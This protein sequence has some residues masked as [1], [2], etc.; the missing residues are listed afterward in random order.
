MS[1]VGCQGSGAGCLGRVSGPGV[2]GRVLGAWVEKRRSIMSIR[3]FRDLRVWKAAMD[4]VEKGLS[5]DAGISETRDLRINKSDT[6]C[7]SFDSFEHSGRSYEGT[8]Q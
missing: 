2:G 7:G 8:S 3:S 6:A 5:S 1:G 4:L